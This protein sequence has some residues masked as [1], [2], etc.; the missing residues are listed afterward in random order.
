MAREIAGCI[1]Q[2]SWGAKGIIR[3]GTA[4]LP[5]ILDGGGEPSILFSCRLAGCLGEQQANCRKCSAKTE[6][7]RPSGSCLA[8]SGFGTGSD[9]LA[10]Q[11][12]ADCWPASGEIFS[13]R[14]RLFICK[15]SWTQWF[16]LMLGLF[17]KRSSSQCDVPAI[18]DSRASSFGVSVGKRFAKV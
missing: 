9:L 1:T 2:S 6:Y 17:A 14:D 3:A 7:A 5:R 16:P 10:Q 15:K 18:G 13:S 8:A 12:R 4:W 11:E